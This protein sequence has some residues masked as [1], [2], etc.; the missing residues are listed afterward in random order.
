MPTPDMQFHCKTYVDYQRIEENIKRFAAS[1]PVSI[2]LFEGENK[3]T[4]KQRGAL[5][6]WCQQCAD[7]LNEAGFYFKHKS[8]FSDKEIETPW[9]MIMFKERAYK[10]ILKVMTE[11]DSTEKQSTVEPSEVAEVIYKHFGDNGLVCPPWPSYR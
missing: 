5:H 7:A 1:H 2:W 3:Y 4:E 10:P 11:K 8:V 6:V 9:T